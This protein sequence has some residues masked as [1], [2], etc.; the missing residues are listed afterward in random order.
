[1]A[2]I[3]KITLPNGSEYNFKDAAARGGQKIY[4]ATCTTAAGTAAKV[5]A[6]TNTD[7]TLETGAMVRVKFTNADTYN[8]TSSLNVDSKGAKNIVRVGT[9]VKPRYNWTAGE[10]V[11]FV[12]DGTYF[13]MSDAGTATTSYYGITALSSSTSSTSE[14]LAATPKAVK[15]AYDLA[16]GKQDPI[17]AGTGISISSDTVSLAS[18][19]VTAGSAGPTAAVTGN[20]GT[21]VAI[22]RIT[23]DTY[24]RVTGLTSYNLT[25]KNTTYT[26]ASATPSAIGT[27]AVGTSAKY[28][29]EDHV[30][31]IALA[32]G[33]SNGQVKIAGTNVSVKGLGSAA[34][35]DT[36]STVTNDAKLP[37]GAAVKAFVE[38]KGYVTTDTK[39]TTGSTDT[40]SKIYL[41]GATSQ[42]ANPQTYSD[43]EVYATSGVL[44]AKKFDGY[45]TSIKTFESR[46]TSGDTLFGDGKLRYFNASSSMTEGK[47]IFDGASHDSNVISMSWDNTGGYDSQ[48]AQN[49]ATGKL[50]VRAMNAGTW[51]DWHTVIDSSGG[52]ISGTLILS[53]TQDASGT[54]NNKPALIVGGTDTQA[55]IEIDANEII[56]KA[57]GTT[58]TTL[59]I[60]GDGGQVYIGAGGV[61]TGGTISSSGDISTKGSIGVAATAETSNLS[62]CKMQYNSST[63]ALDFIFS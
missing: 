50:A 40:S 19:V 2:D 44:T 42:A 55:H 45:A 23:V 20:D 10:V 3:S 48:I 33:D 28:A 25:N 1:M 59:N 29:R 51:G 26:A 15:A 6:T 38:G 22:P 53:R 60:N 24:G 58:T 49:N 21:T 47:P 34:Y 8:G 9:T 4:Y 14:V 56:A 54:A 35:V 17:S 37:T 27:A 30:H 62:Q 32:T 5:A 57:S 41:I 61:R 18:G 39:N 36:E 12:Y 16:D 63:N 52:T 11:D 43:D 31:N 13:V 7:F 46:Q